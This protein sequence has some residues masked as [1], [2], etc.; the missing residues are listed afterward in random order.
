MYIN[1]LHHCGKLLLVKKI[2]QNNTTYGFQRS[3]LFTL[4]VTLT[5]PTSGYDGKYKM[6]LSSFNNLSWEANYFL[7]N[8]YVL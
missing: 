8:Y 4:C 6:H 2:E 5:I 3:V 1:I 7:E